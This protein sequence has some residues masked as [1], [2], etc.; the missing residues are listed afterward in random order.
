MHIA[1][2]GW[3]WDRLDTG[4]GQYLRQL[5]PALRRA[6]PSLILT[7]ILPAHITPPDDLPD[8]VQVLTAGQGGRA[9]RWGKVW[10]E[11]RTFPRLAARSGA[12]LA[13]VPYWGPPLSSKLPLVV[14][15][16]DIIPVL[17]PEYAMGVFNRLYLSLVST[18]TQ[19][20]SHIITLSHTSAIDIER[21]L[22]IPSK[23]ITATYLAPDQRFHPQVGSDHDAEVRRRYDLPPEFVLYLGGFDRRKQVSE[24][25]EAYTFIARAEGTQIPLVIA[26]REPKWRQPLFPNLRRIADEL[27]ISD[28][29][30]WIGYVDEEDKP[31]L[32]RLASV[33]VYPS[34]YEGFG[35]QPLEAM[36]SGTPVVAWEAIHADEILG[37][38]AYLV[39]NARSMAG[40]ILALLLQK[41]FRDAMV[42][43]G[44][45]CASQYSWRKTARE[46]LSAYEKALTRI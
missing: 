25:L 24:L 23:R 37:D 20:A 46:T 16:L 2:N 13:H 45:A 12:D 27:G 8:G 44:R 40:A 5:V 18:A 7:L 19:G 35:M 31:A 6:E 29:V 17:Y 3:F 22:D 32:Y 28:L 4:S 26:G 41:P 36:S 34:M 38:G 1:L 9:S 30:R 15:V 10:F 11:Q 42:N 21:Y 14:S 39:D 33:F 43:Q